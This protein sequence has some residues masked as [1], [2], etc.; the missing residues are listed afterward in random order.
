MFQYFLKRISVKIKKDG[1]SG[2][3]LA[4][5]GY[6]LKLRRRAHYKKMLAIEC[7]KEKFSEIYRQ[8]FW[9]SAESL[10]G[11]GSEVSYTERLRQWLPTAVSEYDIKTIVDAPCGDFN[12]MKLVLPDLNV[13]YFGL[14]IVDSVV[15]R[16]N[17]LYG[18]DGVQFLS[19]DVCRDQIPDCDLLI[20]RD[21]LFHLSFDD[22][23]QFLK[24]ISQS[25]YKYLLTT[26]H[27]VKDTFSNVDIPTGDFRVLDVFRAPF[28]FDPAR[29]LARVDDYPMGHYRPRQ[30][31][32][33]KKSDVPVA[34]QGHKVEDLVLS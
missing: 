5:A 12:W 8:N 20:A 18:T 21:F 15:E 10:S 2:L 30:M 19:S 33:L 4:L 17:A 9:S 24:N 28:H 16:N 29:V 7:R 22:I 11:E 14:D 26:T 1:L 6:P 23:N 31:I 34:L 27:L 3:F 25:N 13:Q 32:L